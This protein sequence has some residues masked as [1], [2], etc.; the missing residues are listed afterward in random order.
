MEGRHW[1]PGQKHRQPL[2]L[3]SHRR[4]CGAVGLN[5]PS[6]AGTPL[7]GQVVLIDFWGMGCGPC[8]AV[9]P[10]VQRL[11]EQFA[12]KGVVV[13]GLHT[14][15]AKPEELQA[16]AKQRQLTFPL[17][18]DVPSGPNSFGKTY[19]A[20]GVR[21]IPAAVLDADGNVAYLGTLSEA[22]GVAGSLVAPSR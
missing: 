2:R 22:V 4:Y 14:A 1:Q 20:Y 3:T 18:I 15:G 13:I 6:H 17:A 19:E 11:A 7:R 12:K 21:R 10:E 8:V 5:T 16:F 9:L